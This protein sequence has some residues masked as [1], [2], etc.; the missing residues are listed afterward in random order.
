MS[1]EM[2]FDST[3]LSLVQSS[4]EDCTIADSVSEANTPSA[5]HTVPQDNVDIFSSHR[6]QIDWC[7]ETAWFRESS[8]EFPPD[9]VSFSMRRSD[10]CENL[11]AAESL[12]DQDDMEPSTLSPTTIAEDNNEAGWFGSMASNE[13]NAIQGQFGTSCMYTHIL[14][15][16]LHCRGNS[17]ND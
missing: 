10:R 11:S 16:T 4:N 1:E 14:A 15:K 9:A 6:E 13:N 3:T 2:S 17:S 7:S 12:P 5:V 8:D